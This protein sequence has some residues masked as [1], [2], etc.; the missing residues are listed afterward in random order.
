MELRQLRYFEAVARRRHFTRAAE[1]LH[2]A[3]SALSHQ[4]RRLE[5]ELGV[6]LLRRTTRL[7]EP[8]EAGMLVAARARAVLAE[9]AALRGEVDELRGLVRGR[10]TVGAMLFGGELD[11][12]AL[13]ASFSRAFP[14]VEL[15]VRE[16]PA[17]EMLDLLDAGGLDITFA[18]EVE[19]PDGVE[20]LELSSEELAVVMSPGHPLAGE[21]PLEIQALAGHPL[22]AFS[23]G[24][25]TRR[26]VDRAL[27][28]AGAELRIAVEAN[29]LALVRS[30]AASGLGVAILPR[31]F[32]E[33][34]G[35]RVAS[36][37][38]VPTLRMTVALWWRRGRPLSPAA[39]GF[40]QFAD[41]HR[42][43][44]HVKQP[45][46]HARAPR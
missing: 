25:S 34:P 16:G 22:I 45:A 8:T 39:R 33:R 4:I 5:Q 37:P 35:P 36:R 44:G 7:V 21:G 13:L 3:Q 38:V 26:L 23:T 32:V 41:D 40:V 24:S 15:R 27:A 17:Q 10:V 29:E 1:E 30:L 19:P 18:L 12:P 2:V 6:E 43:A 28:S 42:P 14:R 20:R 46:P 11:I 9:T 31:S